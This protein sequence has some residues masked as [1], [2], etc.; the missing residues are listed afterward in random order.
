MHARHTLPTSALALRQRVL[1]RLVLASLPALALVAC[2]GGSGAAGGGGGQMPPPQVGVVTVQ[3]TGVSLPTELPGR[4]EAKRVA[5]VRARVTGVVNKRL[6]QEGATVK[7]GQS[8]FQIDAAPY[9]A[10][11]DSAKAQR[12]KAEAALAQAQAQLE[13]NRP[14]A[15][16]KAISQQEWVATQATHKQ[17]QADLAAASA[18][19][20][21][22][23]L[24]VGYA[25]VASPISGRIGRAN[26][27]EGALVSQAEGTLLATVQQVDAL[28]VN[29][30]QSASEVLR[31]KRAVEAGKLRNS[32]SSQ[33]RIVLD[34]GTEYAHA[35]KLLFSD[36]SVDATSGQVTL[37]AEVPNPNGDLLPGLY[38]KVRLNQVATDN[39]MLVPQQAVTRGAS[40][41]TVMV[42][43]A[44]GQVSSRPVQL[45]GARGTQWV[46]LGGLKAGEQVV[47]DG[48]QKIRPKAPVKPVP[49]SPLGA[50]A[51]AG[52][53]T[54]AASAP[55]SAASR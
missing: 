32:G 12:A 14:L 30:T 24:N 31:L 8:L 28:Y 51:P 16:A 18:A 2:G 20:Q 23:Q 43:G 45:G 13:R 11:L 36:L 19:V 10:T 25:G 53:N 35:G 22:A 37:R 46:V 39:A 55:A 1:S 27:T 3:A 48:F 42:V 47:V 50:S 41:D 34:D 40:G 21:Q 17:A 49:W 4:L 54:P 15:E 26:V 7:A 38:V 44:D 6:F 33:V 5:Q 52:A 29:F 9:Q